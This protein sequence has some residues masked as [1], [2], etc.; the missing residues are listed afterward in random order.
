[1]NES[2]LDRYCGT[3]VELAETGTLRFKVVDLHPE[4]GDI[5][6]QQILDQNGIQLETKKSQNVQRI[7]HKEFFL[8]HRLAS[9]EQQTKLRHEL[10]NTNKHRLYIKYFVDGAE[11]LPLEIKPEGL[12]FMRDYDPVFNPQMGHITSIRNR[13][14]GTD[15]RFVDMTVNVL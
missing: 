3:A 1:M 6:I 12:D 11:C 13:R 9:F 10:V 15:I 5:S 14:L 7:N 4:T 8:L 2:L